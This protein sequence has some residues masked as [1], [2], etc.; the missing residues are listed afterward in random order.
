QRVTAAQ[1]D[2]DKAKLQLARIIG[3]PPGQS[4]TL[5]DPIRSVPFPDLT[6][7]QAL[8]RGY[9]NRGDYQ[10]ALERVHAAEA[11][12]AA[13]QGENLPS[14]RVTADYGDIGLTPAD[15]H[16]SFNL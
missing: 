4:F 3:L 1:V 11:S 6:L 10:A 7:E 13:I 2:A 16:A 15:A 9:K 5:A 12:R 14:V 8:E